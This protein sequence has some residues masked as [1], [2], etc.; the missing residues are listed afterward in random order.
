MKVKKIVTKVSIKIIK[1]IFSKILACCILVSIFTGYLLPQQVMANGHSNEVNLGWVSSK[2]KKALIEQMCWKQFKKSYSS[3]ANENKVFEEHF[4]LENGGDFIV[5]K[6][7]MEW[8]TSQGLFLFQIDVPSGNDKFDVFDFS[9][10]TAI[11]H[12]FINAEKIYNNNEYKLRTVTYQKFIDWDKA[13]FFDNLE[14]KGLHLQ[15]I[16]LTAESDEEVINSELYQKELINTD[17]VTFLNIGG[18]NFEWSKIYYK[19]IT[20]TYLNEKGQEIDS[21]NFKFGDNSHVDIQR[22]NPK[23]KKGY[24]WTGKYSIDGEEFNTDKSFLNINYGVKE[25]KINLIYKKKNSNDDTKPDT[26]N[27]DVTPPKEQEGSDKG[28]KS[29]TDTY[30][31]DKQSIMDRVKSLLHQAGADDTVINYIQNG[32]YTLFNNW[33]ETHADLI[34]SNLTP[35]QGQVL[36]NELSKITGARY[37]ITWPCEITYTIITT[38]IYHHYYCDRSS[39]DEASQKFIV[40]GAYDD[41]E[42]DGQSGRDPLYTYIWNKNT[43]EYFAGGFGA[44]REIPMTKSGSYRAYTGVYGT[45]DCWFTEDFEVRLDETKPV[46]DKVTPIAPTGN[47]AGITLQIKVHDDGV[48]LKSVTVENTKDSSKKWTKYFNGEKSTTVEQTVPE[49]A[50]YKIIAEDLNGNTEET[51]ETVEVDTTPPELEGNPTVEVKYNTRKTKVDGNNSAKIGDDIV[52][53]LKAN[54]EIKSLG[55]P[56]QEIAN[57]GPFR[58]FNMKE[59]QYDINVNN[60]NVL[61]FNSANMELKFRITEDVLEELNLKGQEGSVGLQLYGLRDKYNNVADDSKLKFENIF[62]LDDKAPKLTNT[63]ISAKDNKGYTDK[64]DQN[65]MIIASGNKY[66][67]DMTFDEELNEA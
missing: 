55:N 60:G 46:I 2:L 5:S 67:I 50:K 27:K 28:S 25:K 57:N 16:V 37:S 31:D 59:P 63:T 38:N 33:F 15:Q 58:I 19:P 4:D 1:N 26:K 6:K 48:G 42:I 47:N 36:R 30:A 54:E 32:Q 51:T 44:D 11:K 21:E 20:I 65:Y 29:Q 12:V 39:Y 40:K 64:D 18:D 23:E 52:I 7:W 43:N 3:F 9:K 56:L 41:W 8:C 10:F 13:Y 49:T 17:N 35:A 34:T 24:E 45:S 14:E 62:Y 61:T 22:I 53:T 66:V